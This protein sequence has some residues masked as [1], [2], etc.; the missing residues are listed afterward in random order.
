[1]HD[2]LIT[3]E[4]MSDDVVS[5]IDDSTYNADSNKDI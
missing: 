4:Q 1:M 2:E 5:V 3:G